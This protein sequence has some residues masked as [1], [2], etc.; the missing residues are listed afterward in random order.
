MPVEIVI[1]A[2]NGAERI[3]LPEESRVLFDLSV[4][5]EAPDETPAPTEA[6]VPEPTA[7]PVLSP[8]PG[9]SGDGTTPA[10]A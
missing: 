4:E 2:V 7:A 9:S 5:E 8:E 6:P 1:T 3:T 10:K